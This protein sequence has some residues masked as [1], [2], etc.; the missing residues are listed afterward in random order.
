MVLEGDS[1]KWENFLFLGDDSEE[2]VRRHFFG[3]VERPSRMAN[4]DVIGEKSKGDS[5]LVF[6]T[7]VY[8]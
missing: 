6:N 7:D 4:K 5:R 3:K 2:H 1:H 8:E